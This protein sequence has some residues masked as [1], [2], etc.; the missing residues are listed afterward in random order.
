VTSPSALQHRQ[1]SQREPAPEPFTPQRRR[2][3]RV[4]AA[5]LGAA[6][7]LAAAC[8]LTNEEYEPPLIASD[9]L[10]GSEGNE[11]D[12]GGCAD[13][14]QCCDA[15]PCPEGESCIA[16]ACRAPDAPDASVPSTPAECVG[17][18]C[19]GNLP[20]VPLAPSCDDGVQN[21]DETGSD[22]GG[23]CA[24]ACGAGA[25][26]VSDADCADG[27]VC[28]EQTARCS[29]VSCGDGVLNGSE[30][31]TDCG[32]GCP[33]C[34]DGAACNTGSD[35]QSLVCGD[36]G[37]CAEPACNDEQR[38][39]AETGT[40]CGGPCPQNCGNG[41][42]CE[43]NDDCQSGVCGGQ[44]CAA[45][46]ERCCQPPDCDDDVRNGGESDVDCGSFACGQCALGDSC[47]INLQCNTGLCQGG[48]CA[49][50]PRCDDNLENGTESDVDC[51]GSCA[52][53]ADLRDCE[54]AADCASNNCDAAGTCISCGDAVRN[55]TETGV[56]CGG[57][58]LACRRC[59]AGEVCASNTDCVNQF[60]LGGFCT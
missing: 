27:L 41:G 23:G 1:T 18:D 4:V 40:D 42:G 57:A 35:C 55:G 22:C 50:P 5:L 43:S 49:N 2:A 37:N 26:C 46:V 13:G 51:G 10:I 48:V 38:N 44:G 17:T 47:L 20:P 8:T 19:P 16:G 11:P 32:G 36:D 14:T 39:G 34:A 58:D 28:P 3:G 9:A 54:Q 12:A 31:G 53:C 21:G 29:E 59:N 6:W 56:D 7:A 15:L 25:G 30:T 24:R 45:G 52:P 33:G 60:C